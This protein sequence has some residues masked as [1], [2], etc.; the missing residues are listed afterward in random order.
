MKSY[1]KR[2]NGAEKVVATISE[3][4]D[5]ITTEQSLISFES[6]QHFNFQAPI[7]YQNLALRLVNSQKCE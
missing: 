6:L 1:L 7:A 4:R 2:R 3:V 5:P